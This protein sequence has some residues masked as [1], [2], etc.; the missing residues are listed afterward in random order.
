MGHGLTDSDGHRLRCGAGARSRGRAAIAG[1]HHHG[2]DPSA[3]GS[4]GRRRALPVRPC[5]LPSSWSRSHRDRA[6][7]MTLQIMFGI[8]G[9]RPAAPCYSERCGSN[10]RQSLC[11]AQQAPPS[12]GTALLAAEW[13]TGRET[14]RGGGAC[15]AQCCAMSPCGARHA[16]PG[17]TTVITFRHQLTV[18]IASLF[19][20]HTS[21]RVLFIRDK[22]SN[23]RQWCLS[24]TASDRAPRLLRRRLLW[25]RAFDTLGGCL[26][27]DC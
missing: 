9:G 8:V 26:H 25:D 19:L 3:A 15:D 22:S 11:T 17:P 23:T 7:R 20:C 24:V 5:P 16:P 13:R 21:P 1:R 4:L 6:L 14:G 12:G 2:Q 27:R 10:A 18:D